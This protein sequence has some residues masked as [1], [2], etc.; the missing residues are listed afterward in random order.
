MGAAPKG[1]A[2]AAATFG[3]G[4]GGKGVKG[5]VAGKGKGK[6]KNPLKSI[7][8]KLKIWVNK[9]PAE[10]DWKNVEA[11]FEQMGKTQWVELMP[12]GVG[13]IAYNT[14]EEAAAALGLNGM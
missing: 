13:C 5:K 9:L 3:N 6:G 10:V 12:R 2:A 4:F 11:H 7:D 1:G 8:N 14:E